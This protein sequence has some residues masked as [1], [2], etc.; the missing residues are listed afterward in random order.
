MRTVLNSGTCQ[1]VG[2]LEKKYQSKLSSW[3]TS[4]KN[5]HNMFSPFLLSWSK[6]TTQ[7][8]SVSIFH[9]KKF[10]YLRHFG[11]GSMMWLKGLLDL[12]VWWPIWW[13]S[14]SWP[15]SRWHPTSTCFSLS[16]LPV[17]LPLL[18]LASLRELRATSTP[19]STLTI[20][21]TCCGTHFS[22]WLWLPP[23]TLPSVWVVSATEA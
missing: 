17:T 14:S 8:M 6:W 1:V 5:L 23:S 15:G 21:S 11:G 18:S 12:L 4:R 9:Q 13:Q 19:K 16:W 10:Q 3:G 7:L 22:T 2:Y 20:G